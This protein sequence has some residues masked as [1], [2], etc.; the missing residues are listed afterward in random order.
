MAALHPGDTGAKKV[1]IASQVARELRQRILDG[2]MPPGEKINLELVRR[3]FDI[4]VSSVREAMG[5]L[6]TE[7]LVAFEDHRGYR[8]APV[9]FENLKE[10]TFLRAELEAMALRE[11]MRHGNVEWESAVMGALYRLNH[12]H[13]EA[14]NIAS[15]KTWEKAHRDFH[16]ELIAGCRMPQLLQFCNVLH[17]QN[18]RYRRL[19][20]LASSGDRDVAAEHTAIAEAAISYDAETACALLGRHIE[21]TGT[22]LLNRLRNENADLANVLRQE[23]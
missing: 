16:M 11:T 1:T 4:S 5:K 3:D 19:F 9:S 14:G 12:T 6:V 21:R 15:I 8:V 18:D 13:R 7:G 2:E 23:G 22:N 20:L 10:I 17:S